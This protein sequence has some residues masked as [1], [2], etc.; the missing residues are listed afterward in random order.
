MTFR[1]AILPPLIQI[2]FDARWSRNDRQRPEEYLRR[3]AAVAADAELAV[4]VIYAEYFARERSGE[5]PELAEY[6]ARFPAFA[7]VL[8]EQIRLHHAF[9]TLDDDD[10]QLP[11]ADA[12]PTRSGLS[13]TAGRSLRSG[14]KL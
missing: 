3:F 4:D 10:V 8:A 5:K 1:L 7:H 9:D 12:E 2:D 13:P 11:P 14:C 6:Q